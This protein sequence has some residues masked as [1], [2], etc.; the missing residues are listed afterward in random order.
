MIR[1]LLT[2]ILL[3]VSLA[4][5]SAAQTNEANSPA[6]SPSNTTTPESASKSAPGTPKKVWTNENISEASTK[7]SVVGTKSDQKYTLTKTADPATVE[8]IR[9]ELK[10]LQ[11]QVE[12]IKKQ[13]ATYKDFK[14][15]EPVSGSGYQVDKGYG[16]IPVEQQMVMLEKKK[17]DLET[18]IDEQLD[19]ARK[20]GI[21]PGQLR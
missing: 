16:R 3:L 6:Q 12:D 7:I 10:K 14:E 5:P 1:W 11:G 17:K 9:K 8:R 18:Q 21:D 2:L 13:L 4:L 19:E 15:G 20:K